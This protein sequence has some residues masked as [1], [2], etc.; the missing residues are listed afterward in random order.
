MKKLNL[1]GMFIP[2]LRR[3]EIRKQPLAL[4]DS[5]TMSWDDL[6]GYCPNG[7]C[8]NDGCR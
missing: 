2:V 3:S 8:T 7:G 4:S 1:T 5:K 6:N